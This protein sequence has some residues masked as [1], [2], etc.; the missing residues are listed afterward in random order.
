MIN[1]NFFL[2]DE[3]L[4]GFSISGHA[5]FDDFG[6]DIVCA[7]VT[8]AVQLCINGITE[9]LHIKS[10]VEVLKNEINFS[11][12]KSCDNQCAITFLKALYLHID[13]LSQDYPKNIKIS[14][15]EV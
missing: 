15:V 10:N 14:T 4:F 9:C 13:V 5:D 12:L 6:K 3:T 7:S 2:K 1:A 11:L 8:S